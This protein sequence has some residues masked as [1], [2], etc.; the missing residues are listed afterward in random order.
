VPVCYDRSVFLFTSFPEL[1]RPFGVAELGD[2]QIVKNKNSVAEI[3]D[4][5]SSDS[6]GSI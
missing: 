2:G 3:S 5:A 6:L 1:V 4:V